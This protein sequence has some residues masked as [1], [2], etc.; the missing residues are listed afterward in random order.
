MA[1]RVYRGYDR[2]PQDIGSTISIRVP[3][4]FTAQDAPS[5]AQD[6]STSSISITLDQWK[7]VKFKLTDKELTHTGERIINEHIRPAAYALADQI[8]TTLAALYVLV[9]WEE[10]AA[11]SIDVSDR[12]RSPRSRRS[13]DGVAIA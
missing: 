7:E 3:S 6:L 11:S 4:T 10:A 8:D 12:Y 5:S 1:N 2:S 9:P 13:T